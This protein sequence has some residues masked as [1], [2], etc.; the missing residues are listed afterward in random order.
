MKEVYTLEE[1][2]DMVS[3][4]YV[5]S[6][7]LTDIISSLLSYEFNDDIK[8][9]F[10]NLANNDKLPNAVR[11]NLKNV[12]DSYNEI[13]RQTNKEASLTKNDLDSEFVFTEPK[14]STIQFGTEVN[15]EKDG[16]EISLENDAILGNLVANA[17]NKGINVVSSNPGLT[18]TPE[19]TLELT[20]DSKPYIDNLLLELY[21][22]K[23]DIDIDMTRINSTNQEVLTIK[24]NDKKLS[25]EELMQKGKEIFNDVNEIINQTDKEKDYESLM[26][27]ELQGL[28]DKFVNDDPN[29][30]NKDFTV[31]YSNS[32]GITSF[33]L[34]ADSKQEAIEIAE[35]I[36]Y[37]IK[38]DRGGNV[39][40]LDTE[41]KKMDGTKLDK[42]SLEVDSIDEVKDTERGLPDIEVEYNAK[43]YDSEDSLRVLDFINDNKDSDDMAVVQ[44]DIPGDT[45]NQ[46]IVNLASSDGT[47]E[48]IIFNNG[49]EFDTYT[50]P[51]VADS[52]GKGASID[53][54]NVT[55]VEYENGKASYEALSSDNN[56]LRINNYD[57]A[58]IDKVNDSLNGYI[59]ED[60]P[61]KQEQKNNEYV[62]TLG[63][64]PTNNPE[65]AKISFLT[66]VVFIL[67]MAIGFGIIYFVYGG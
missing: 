11:T 53:R 41:N 35:L 17:S 7:N 39:F 56:Y 12:V 51:K 63:T 61:V 37:E 22:N 32:D 15:L 6:S 27:S 18:D 57:S 23:K 45:P 34:I 31:G 66:L 48:T 16:D 26:P 38:K 43:H 2:K 46:R 64:Y 59:K 21:K 54:N 13:E 62:K 10:E 33:Y 5:N 24:A 40:E 8:E 42:A 9:I 50:L 3:N 25:E 47:R 36:G 1:V 49:T 30:P 14:I 65:S 67:V 19:I 44:I 60:T 20:H 55:K 4:G 58:T 28:K 29:I 52:F